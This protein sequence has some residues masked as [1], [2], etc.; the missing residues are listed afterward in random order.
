MS[1]HSGANGSGH[2]APELTRRQWSGAPILGLV[3]E[4]N[5]LCIET[6]QRLATHDSRA[7]TLD[8]VTS[9][10]N[11]WRGLDVTARQRAAKCPF[12]LLDAR[13]QSETWWR[14]AGR[15]CTRHLKG[16]A[17]PGCLPAKTGATLMRETLTLAWHTSR[18]DPRASSLLLG[19]SPAVA[20]LIAGM[21]LQDIER[22]AAG[23]HC[24]L[25]PRWED[26]LDFWRQLLVAARNGDDETLRELHLHGLQ[27]AGGDLIRHCGRANTCSTHI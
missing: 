20:E 17:R 26:R 6:L 21:G 19:V 8:L 9:L 25:R 4:V 18:L 3:Y 22:V 16:V 27:L 24:H 12:L 13:F 7:H 14:K 1:P 2:A 10:R 23:Q 15:P 5:E 11:L